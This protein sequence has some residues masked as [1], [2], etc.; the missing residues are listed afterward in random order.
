MFI[1]LNK[2]GYKYFN[3]GI[4]VLISIVTLSITA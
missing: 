2:Y 4:Y 3:W 1:G